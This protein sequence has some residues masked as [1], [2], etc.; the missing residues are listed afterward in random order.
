M[1]KSI[2]VSS[3]LWRVQSQAREDFSHEREIR[4]GIELIDR[5]HQGFGLIRC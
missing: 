5:G 2:A 3:R 1:P 4:L